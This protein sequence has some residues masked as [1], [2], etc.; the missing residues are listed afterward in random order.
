MKRTTI[1]LGVAATFVLGAPA[2]A[3]QAA[4]AHPAKVTAPACATKCRPAKP[5]PA[6]GWKCAKTKSCATK[7]HYPVCPP[8]KPP[9]TP[10][11]KPPTSKPH[12][13]VITTVVHHSTPHVVADAP[14]PLPQLAFTAS[15]FDLAPYVEGGVALVIF[16][17]GMIAAT[18]KAR[19]R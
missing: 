13:P 10:P 6:G 4:T 3:A 9:V 18:G 8:V 19:A 5:K 7:H 1:I 11:V 14:K 12:T 17:F 15:T 16:G 2:L